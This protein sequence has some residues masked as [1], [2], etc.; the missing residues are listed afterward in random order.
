MNL[1]NLG[2][3]LAL[4]PVVALVAFAKP[5]KPTPIVFPKGSKVAIV[6]GVLATKS[7]TT[8]FTFTATKGQK[9]EVKADAPGT[10]VV[11]LVFPDKSSDGAPV[12][13]ET[14]VPKAGVCTIEVHSKNKD[15]KGKFTLTVKKL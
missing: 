2:V 15:W 4:L 3:A 8:S 10:A 6:K 12:G 13:I 1:K 11:M 5:G 14:E 7:S 9:L